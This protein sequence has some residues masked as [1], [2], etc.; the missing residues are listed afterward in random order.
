MDKPVIVQMDGSIL[1]DVHHSDADAA[2]QCLV[3]FAELEKSPDHFHTYRVTALSLW[4]AASAG[5]RSAEIVENLRSISR[6]D[7]P[8]PIIRFITETMDRYGI[9][10]LHRGENGLTLF[11]HDPLALLEVTQHR[12]IAPFVRRNVSASA[13]EIPLLARGTIKVALTKLGYPVRD[14]AGYAEGQPLQFSLR[15]FLGEGVPFTLRDYQEQAAESFHEGGNL[16]G[17]SGVLT[18]PCGAGKTIIGLRAMELLQTSTLILAANVTAARQWIHECIDKT[19]LTPDQVAE[20]SGE[21]KMT[22]PVTV[23]TYQILSYRPRGKDDFPHLSLLSSH[24]W[25][26]I[27]YD[28]VH[29]LP[30]PVFRITAEIQAR[31]RLGLTAT[32]VREDGKEE[33]VFSLIGPKKFDA[34]WKELEAQGYIATA[35]CTEVRVGLNDEERRH[36]AVSELREKARIAAEAKEKEDAVLRLVARHP[37]DMILIIGQ[38]IDQLK[39]IAEKLSAPLITGSTKSRERDELYQAFRI[40]ELRVLVVSKVANFSIDLP[41]ASVAIQVSGAFGSRQEE[42]QRLGRIMRPKADGM[43]AHFYSVVTRETKD[44]EFALGRQRFLTEQG[45]QYDIVDLADLEE[46]YA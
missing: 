8:P 16:S 18:L 17:G 12:S 19:T 46:V 32:L 21:S 15:E 35:M 30:A 22:A 39:R 2:R 37:Q 7:V 26:L 6:Y 33:E 14:L 36:Y 45:Y 43:T 34:P 42:A 24:N 40:G 31:R 4:N 25:G 3:P 9:L 41:D 1:L 44:Q 11:S 23:A 13:V 29:L 28:E 5:H 38:Y 10:E 20:Y 27:I